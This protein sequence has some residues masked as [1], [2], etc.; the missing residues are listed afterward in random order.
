M[1]NL[2]VLNVGT[3][4]KLIQDLK[5]TFNGEGKI[6]V[7]DNYELAPALYEGDKF[8]ITPWCESEGYLEV[9][10][11]ICKKENVK[12]ILSLLDPDLPIIAQYKKQFEALGIS[13]FISD[14]K[15]IDLSFDKYSTYCEAMKREIQVVKTYIDLNMLRQSLQE[16]EINFPLIGKPKC[17]SG[18]NEV[19]IFHNIA[20]LDSFTPPK[21]ITMIYQK[22]MT[23]QE[24]GADVYIDILSKEVVGIFTK[25][26]LKMRAGE[27]DKSESFKDPALFNFIIDICNKFH[28]VGPLDMDIFYQDGKYY[29]SEINPRFGGGYLHAYECGVNFPRMILNNL[30]KERNISSVGNYQEHTYMMKYF[31]VRILKKEK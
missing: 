5:E 30:K 20:E 22:F 16:G 18:S 7:T 6:I 28:F 1:Y 2:L 13:C 15:Y 3:R 14:K 31:D 29:L 25:K 24:I 12:G 17:G 26:K 8:Y 10:L 23:G 21:D 27:T 4:N 19:H 9:I 11:D